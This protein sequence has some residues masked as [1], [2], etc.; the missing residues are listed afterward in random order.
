MLHKSFK[1]TFPFMLFLHII[2]QMRMRLITLKAL[3]N[4]LFLQLKPGV[5]MQYARKIF[6]LENF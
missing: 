5:I 3:V 6:A 2:F 4:I 1:K